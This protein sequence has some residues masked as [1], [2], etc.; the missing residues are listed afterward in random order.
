M[1]SQDE[2]RGDWNNLKG[3]EY[4]LVY[5]LWLLLCARASEVA[6]YEGND[7]R[8][9]PISPPALVGHTEAAGAIPLR[10]QREQRDVWFQLKS[11]TEP[12]TTSDFLDGNLLPNFVCNALTSQRNGR[13]WEV[14]LVTQAIVKRK[15]V[16][17]FADDPDVQPTLAKKLGRVIASVVDQFG[18]A[19]GEPPPGGEHAV[20]ES[21]PSAS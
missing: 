6:F 3:T 17:A 8:A 20:R 5:A 11:T 1:L 21:L 15:D 4:H 10:T 14:R 9:Q 18:Q 19:F 7:L 13:P 16:L 12:W 2:I